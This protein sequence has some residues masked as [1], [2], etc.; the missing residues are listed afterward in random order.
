MFLSVLVVFMLAYAI[1]AQSLQYPNRDFY[2]GI[3][4][5]ILYYPWWQL[6]GEMELEKSLEGQST[7]GARNTL[8]CR[9][10]RRLWQQHVDQLRNGCS[11]PASF[12]AGHHDVGLLPAHRQHPT[13]Q[14]AHRHLRVS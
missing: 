1:V 5:D 12:L 13:R 10:D 14:L 7:Q 9:Q 4:G 3:F 8:I 6:F 11:V 2:W